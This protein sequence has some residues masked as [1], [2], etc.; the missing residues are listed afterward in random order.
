M[1]PQEA[2]AAAVGGGQ[3]HHHHHHHRSPADLLRERWCGIFRAEHN[4][5]YDV[6]MWRRQVWPIITLQW[7]PAAWQPPEQLLLEQQ[8]A[9]DAAVKKAL[10]REGDI[11]GITSTPT[12][13]VVEGIGANDMDVDEDTE[14]AAAGR[15]YAVGDIDKEGREVVAL[16]VDY[17][18]LLAGQQTGSQE[19]SHVLLYRVGL[20]G[21]LP[22]GFD[23]ARQRLV[24]VKGELEAVLV[25]GGQC[26]YYM[27]NT[28]MWVK[29]CR[30]ACNILPL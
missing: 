26:H 24:M 4:T 20:P 19:Q 29:Q 23:P 16:P 25:S 1:H 12:G 13:G 7:Q 3:Q 9:A 21:K 15:R 22:A 6:L 17:Q 10:G 30:C 8:T 28:P 11:T 2:L 14:A 18:Y 5:L 27:G